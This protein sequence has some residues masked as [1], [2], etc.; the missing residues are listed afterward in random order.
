MHAAIEVLF[1]VGVFLTLGL[2]SGDA[3]QAQIFN[4]FNLIHCAGDDVDHTDGAPPERESY[5]NQVNVQNVIQC[6]GTP[7]EQGACYPPSG[8]TPD[9]NVHC[10]VG[11]TQLAFCYAT[12]HCGGSVG[13]LSCG[14]VNREALAGEFTGDG[15]RYGFILCRLPSTGYI[16]KNQ[17]CEL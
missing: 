6:H 9:Y 2:T 10:N 3:A 12:Y 17:T 1:A 14:G 11:P 15:K 7:G 4:W 8:N 16:Y 5:T 13:T